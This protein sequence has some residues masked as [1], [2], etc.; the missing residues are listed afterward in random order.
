MAKVEKS[1]TINAPLEKVFEYVADP[2]NLPEIWC[3][4]IDI[5]DVYWTVNG[6][7][8]RWAYKMA[9]MLFEGTAE[10][11]EHTVNKRIVTN[12]KGGL[13]STIAWTFESENGE[14]KVNFTV[15]YKVPIPLLGKLAEI[16]ITKINDHQGDLVMDNLKARMEG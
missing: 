16:I 12:T 7:R 2:T 8:M 13:N 5:K 6:R 3:S 9:G 10:D 15:A 14:T 4:L 11:L 1:I